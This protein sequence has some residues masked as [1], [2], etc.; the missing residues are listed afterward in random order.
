[1]SVNFIYSFSIWN[2]NKVIAS[3]SLQSNIYI[4]PIFTQHMVFIRN[5]KESRKALKCYIKS[6]KIDAG[7]LFRLSND[8]LESLGTHSLETL[9]SVTRCLIPTLGNVFKTASVDKIAQIYID[10]G[11]F[12]LEIKKYDSIDQ[13]DILQYALSGEKSRYFMNGIEQKILE[14]NQKLART[15]PDLLE[16]MNERLESKGLVPIL[17]FKDITCKVTSDCIFQK[18]LGISKKREYQELLKNKFDHDIS[19][20]SQEMKEQLYDE[21]FETNGNNLDTHFTNDLPK[22]L[23]KQNY[24]LL[25]SSDAYCHNMADEPEKTRGLLAKL[26]SSYYSKSGDVRY[27]ALKAYYIAYFGYGKEELMKADSGIYKTIE[28]DGKLDEIPDK[29][30][31]IHT[32]KVQKAIAN[33]FGNIKPIKGKI[34][35]IF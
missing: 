24:N 31:G 29:S 13:H 20:Y 22:E 16:L 17:F 11:T 25:I 33:Y 3:L 8:Y 10:A 35:P 15:H 32:E 5:T 30:I 23:R 12:P 4:G 7:E 2:I 19:K 14:E 26:L 27:D 1:M 6:S 34:N 9:D 21:I 28:R 18:V